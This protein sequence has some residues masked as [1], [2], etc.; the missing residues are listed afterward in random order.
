A[1]GGD[2]LRWRRASRLPLP[3]GLVPRPLAADQSNSAVAYGDRLLLKLYRRP[4]P[5]PHLE[6]ETL[7]ALTE[8]RCPRTPGLHGTLHDDATGLVLGIVEDFLPVAA[9]GWKAAVRQVADCVDGTCPTVPATGGFTSRARTLGRAVAE[10]HTALADAFGRQRADA[11]DI[12]QDAALMTQRLK[13]AAEEVPA[14]DRHRTRLAAL[15]DQYARA[16]TRGCPLFVQR[17]H[18]DLHLGQALPTDDGWHLIDFEGEPARAAAERAA[19]QPVLR[20][21]AGMLRSFDYAARAGLRELDERHPDAGPADR[22]R[23]SRRAHAWTVRNRRAFMDGYAE[24]DGTDPHC[25]PLHLRAFEADKAVYE[26]VYEARH[27]PDWLPI[28]LA[29]LHRIARA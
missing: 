18:G 1:G 11:D 13:L 23:R 14:L 15:Y 21:V 29:A 20:D 8:A 17:V 4:E 19:P 16:A 6:A 24:A 25:H 26:A 2:G 9:D 3:V 22:L 5:G 12:A 28:P 7:R 27:R 10:V